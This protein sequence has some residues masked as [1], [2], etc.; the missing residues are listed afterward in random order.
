M[1]VFVAG[2]TGYIGNQIIEQ[3]LKDGHSVRTLVRKGS[4]QKLRSTSAKT[5]QGDLTD[6][7]LVAAALEGCSAVVY[8]IGLLRE[9][10]S[11]GISFETAHV[12][13]VRSLAEKALRAG[14]KRWIHISANGVRPDTPDGY[15]RT[16]YRAEEFIKVQDLDY[17]I[18]RPSVV[19]GGETDRTVN[20][21]T[22]VRDI[23]G[24]I[25]LVV[26]VIGS[27]SYLMQ[28]VHT[29]D[30]AT[31][32]SA[33]IDMR[34]TFKKT[35]S[36]CGKQSI[37]YNS[38]VDRVTHMYNLK[39]KIKIHIPV[40]FIR[41]LAALFQQFKAFPVTVEQIDMLVNGNTCTDT[42]LFDELGMTPQSFSGL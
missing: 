23:I 1:N 38:I 34:S 18:L 2:G 24:S 21:V 14:I 42:S 35:Y 5:I 13:G 32:V 20:F 29:V 39:K 40:V 16:K 12:T 41:T 28:P 6:P 9:F 3:L 8:C 19:F 33:I 7:A 25:P 37:S 17:T 10:P 15:R 26:P 22:A 4:G 27:G 31:A 30:L 11:Q 36:V